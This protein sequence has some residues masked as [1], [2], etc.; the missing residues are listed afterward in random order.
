[1]RGLSV[2]SKCT[3]IGPDGHVMFVIGVFD[4][5]EWVTILGPHFIS[6]GKRGYHLSYLFLSLKN[7]VAVMWWEQAVFMLFTLQPYFLA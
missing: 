7:F 4:T 2:L 6:Q 1:M 5:E 3:I